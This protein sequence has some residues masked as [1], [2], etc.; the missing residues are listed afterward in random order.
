LTC[1]QNIR[2]ASGVEYHADGD[3]GSKNV[4]QIRFIIGVVVDISESETY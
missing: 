2:I 3:Q 4:R 1:R